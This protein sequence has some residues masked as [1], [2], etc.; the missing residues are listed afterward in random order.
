MFTSVHSRA[1]AA[2]RRISAET[3][4][5]G[6]D[7]H[8]LV[9]L[10]FEALLRHLK[11]AQG[12]LDRNDVAAKGE[13]LGKALRIIEEGL[14][15][16]LNVREGGEIAAN[17]YQL[18]SYAVVRLTHANLRNDRVALQEVIDLLEPVAQSWQQIKGTGPAYLQPVPALGA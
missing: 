15:A 11:T 2:Y 1:A 6:A 18:Y 10:L 13:T 3:S 17:L 7:P 5:Q 8:Q 4:V 16:G 12:A 9:S 14:K